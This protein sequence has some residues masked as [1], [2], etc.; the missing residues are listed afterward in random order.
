MGPKAPSLI[1]EQGSSVGPGSREEQCPFSPDESAQ[2]GQRPQSREFPL[3][4]PIG[5]KQAG[6]VSFTVAIL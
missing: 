1:L 3:S 2:T 6:Q 4:R 5:N